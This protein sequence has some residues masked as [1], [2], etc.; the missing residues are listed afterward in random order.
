MNYQIIAEGFV[1]ERAIGTPTSLAAG[2]RC[3]E[4][5]GGELICTFVAQTAAGGNDFKPMIARSKDGGK[6]WS[7]ARMLWPE[8]QDKF[9][10]FGSV[11]AGPTGDL[12]FYGMRTPIAHPGE[13]AWSPATSGLKEND[14]VWTRS[15]DEGETWTPFSVIPMPIPGSAEAAGAMCITRGGHLVCCYAPCNTFDPALRVEKNQVIC[16]TSRDQGR[17][18][19]HSAMLRFAGA[20]S[21]GAESWVV[22]LADGRLLGAGWHIQGDNAQTNKYAVSAD[23]GATWGPTASTG[24]LGQSTALA[25][26]PD[27]RALFIY[28]QRKHGDVGVWLALVKPTETDFGIALNQRIWAAQIASRNDASADFKDWTSFAFG[29]PSVTPLADGTILA[30]LWAQQPSGHGIR[31]VKLRIQ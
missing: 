25:A 26:M 8:I 7:E 16:L 9:S 30:T 21:Q 19:K 18:W 22:E 29:E 4:T 6:T 3:V 28:N 15:T 2:S 27:G 17:S 12:Y 1:S 14:L 11:S 5:K 24:I 10:I 31:Y 20:D 23:G 13:Q